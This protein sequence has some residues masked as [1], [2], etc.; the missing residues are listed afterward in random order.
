MRGTSESTQ[1]MDEA[2]IGPAMQA[3]RASQGTPNR[4][5]WFEQNCE[6]KL[7]ETEKMAFAVLLLHGSGHDRG[8]TLVSGI[9]AAGTA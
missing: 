8:N 5:D 7:T 4:G 3:E 9:Q 6:R 2:V 1:R